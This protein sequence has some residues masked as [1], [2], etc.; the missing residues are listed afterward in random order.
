M[1]ETWCLICRDRCGTGSIVLNIMI[2]IWILMVVG[3]IMGVFGAAVAG[4]LT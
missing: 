1:K 4:A 2:G 3:V